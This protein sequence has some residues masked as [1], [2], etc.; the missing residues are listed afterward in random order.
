MRRN[1]MSVFVL[2]GVLPT[3][4]AFFYHGTMCDYAMNPLCFF[5]SCIPLLICMPLLALKDEDF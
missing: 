1:I 4:F 3:A 2:F 5:I